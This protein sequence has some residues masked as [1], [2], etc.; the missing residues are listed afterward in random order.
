MLSYVQMQHTPFCT[1]LLWCSSG[2]LSCALLRCTDLCG[3]ETKTQSSRRRVMFAVGGCAAVGFAEIVQC[4]TPGCRPRTPSLPA[5]ARGKEERRLFGPSANH[6]KGMP[7]SGK[8]QAGEKY[9]APSLRAFAVSGADPSRRHGAEVDV[10]WLRSCWFSFRAG[11]FLPSRLGPPHSCLGRVLP[12][13]KI[14]QGRRL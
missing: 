2:E 1:L 3:D 10:A 4:M 9:A 14:H 13:R 11:S 5:R 6:A 12:I 8:K 7:V